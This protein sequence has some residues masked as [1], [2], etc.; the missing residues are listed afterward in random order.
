MKSTLFFT[1]IGLLSMAANVQAACPTNGCGDGKYCSNGQCFTLLKNGKTC[2]E[3]DECKSERC[4][5]YFYPKYKKIC[6][7]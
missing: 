2:K 7:A 5:T 3:N 4:A 1:V 6:V